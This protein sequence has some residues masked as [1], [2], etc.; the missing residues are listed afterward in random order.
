MR[1]F[2]LIFFV[3]LGHFSFAQFEE[4]FHPMVEGDSLTVAQYMQ[5]EKVPGFSFYAHFGDGSDTT[6]LLGTTGGPEP[7]P[8]SLD[9]RFQAGSMGGAAV[10]LAIL[11]LVQEGHIDLDAPANTYLAKPLIDKRHKPDGPVTVRDL[12]LYKRDFRVDQKPKGYP[13]GIPLPTMDQILAGSGP[14]NTTAIAV[15]GN[16]NKSGNSQFANL[17]LLQLIL[18]TIINNPFPGLCRNS[19]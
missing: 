13:A 2:T 3:F 12:I 1:I 18:D 15:R 7:G 8:I 9:T 19:F 5:Q 11:H 10:C 16:L 14:C 4:N 17:L 6:V